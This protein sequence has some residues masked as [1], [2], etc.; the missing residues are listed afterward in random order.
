MLRLNVY[1]KSLDP[2]GFV[3]AK[4]EKLWNKW[5]W[6]AVVML[7]LLKELISLWKILHEVI[8]HFTF[9][10]AKAPM[11]LPPCKS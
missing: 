7:R 1:I 6:K 8:P 9:T 10:L 3:L 5:T 2:L 11:A 4:M